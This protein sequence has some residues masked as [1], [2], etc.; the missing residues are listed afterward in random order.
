MNSNEIARSIDSNKA[1]IVISIDSDFEKK[2][3][4]GN[5][6]FS[7]QVITD[8]RNSAASSVALGILIILYRILIIKKLVIKG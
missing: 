8:G 3:S 2:L 6:L 1:M 7:I 5:L 4:N